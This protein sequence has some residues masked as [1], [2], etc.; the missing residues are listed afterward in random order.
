[1]KAIILAAGRGS[2]MGAMTENQP[3]CFT[4]LAGKRLLDWQLAAL[5]QAGVQDIC[6][7]GGYAAE[8]LTGGAYTLLRNPDW[9][10]TNMVASL[11]CARELLSTETCI[12]SYAD[13]V[14]RADH[15]QRLMAAQAEL[16]ITYDTAWLDLWGARFSD[17]L[18]DAETFQQEQGILQ[19]IGKR[20]KSLSEIQGQYMGLLKMTPQAWQ[21]IESVCEKLSVE[22]K[23]RL[24]MTSLL[25]LLLRAA[26]PI[27]CIAVEGAWCEVDAQ[28]DV[29][30]YE[31]MLQKKSIWRH[32]WRDELPR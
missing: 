22:E 10:S 26:F 3:K 25:S 14:Y 27:Q 6:V 31:R 19:S 21:K 28:S 18:L 32:D 17:P 2:R 5:K 20:A 12:V 29:I 23:A 24:D 9:E 11:F 7:I 15:I 4:K 8:L 13:I 16:A 30:L 1:M